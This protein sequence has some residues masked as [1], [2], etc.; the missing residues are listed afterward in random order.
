MA[1][2]FDEKFTKT[3][4]EYIGRRKDEIHKS[5]GDTLFVEEVLEYAVP[6]IIDNFG[7]PRDDSLG[8]RK[9]MFLIAAK[10]LFS[11]SLGDAG[12][13]SVEDMMQKARELRR[14]GKLPSSTPETV[15]DHLVP[16]LGPSVAPVIPDLSPG[17]IPW[18]SATVNPIFVKPAPKPDPEETPKKD[19][20]EKSV[21]G[22]ESDGWTTDSSCGGSESD[23]SDWDDS[24]PEEE[25]D[26]RK[27]NPVLE[28]ETD[29]SDTELLTD[30]DESLGTR[31]G[32]ES[33]RESLGGEDDDDDRPKPRR[34]TQALRSTP[35]SMPVSS[36][37]STPASAPV[38][39]PEPSQSAPTSSPPLVSVP[40]EIVRGF[41][42]V[43]TAP[44]PRPTPDPEPS[45]PLAMTPEEEEAYVIV[46][47]RKAEAAPII[48]AH[49]DTKKLAS[50][51][52]SSE[53]YK[54]VFDGYLRGHRD[55]EGRVGKL[56]YSIERGDEFVSKRDG[57]AKVPYKII[58]P[59]G[60]G[61]TD[62]KALDL[63]SEQSGRIDIKYGKDGDRAKVILD[64]SVSVF[65][66]FNAA[67]LATAC[68]MEERGKGVSAG[69]NRARVGH[70]KTMSFVDALRIERERAA[71][72]ESDG[73]SL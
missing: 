33:G 62:F 30:P 59:G 13:L 5:G 66:L 23:T 17:N 4:D 15:P 70:E 16:V 11:K 36:P 40:V 52:R 57:A 10:D 12:R 25:K 38:P 9:A 45:D 58:L 49:I 24:E 61:E 7:E 44:E 63:L 73:F 67:L 69:Q 71:R 28:S 56:Y 1:G 21:S 31:S 54:T 2:T 19:D 37:A 22:D 53:G 27:D 34:W 42:A 55:M 8:W 48:N 51:L 72:L 64:E 68:V 3:L 20:D 50:L 32:S 39:D 26:P 46:A 35:A 43:A 6:Y 65:Q 29:G 60:F 14:V 18:E 41:S 47:R